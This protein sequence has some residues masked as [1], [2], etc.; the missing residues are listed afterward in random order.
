[1]SSKKLENNDSVW[2]Y[3]G[4]PDDDYV[5]VAEHGYGMI[6]NDE[7]GEYFV[8]HYH[9]GLMPAFSSEEL[10]SLE[11]LEAKLRAFEPDARKWKTRFN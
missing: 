7:Y 4:H 2:T 1:M 6:G 9:K 11:E 8:I 3:Y 5:A 10:S